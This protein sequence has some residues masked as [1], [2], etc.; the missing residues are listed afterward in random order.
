MA[1]SMLN[2]RELIRLKNVV[3]PAALGL[4]AAYEV[5]SVTDDVLRLGKPLNESLAA[6]WLFKSFRPHSEEFEKQRNLL[7]S[8]KLTGSQREYAL[9]MM[10]MEEILKE[11]KR[12]TE[13]ESNQLIDQGGM[14]LI[15]GSPIISQEEIDTARQKLMERFDRVKDYALVEG[16]GRELEN[17]ALM[18]E[19]EDMQTAKTGEYTSAVSE[20]SFRL[21]GQRKIKS[22]ENY[23]LASSPIF[24]GPQRLVNIAPRPTNIGRGPMTGKS[25][26]KLDYEIPGITPSHKALTFSDDEIL[27][28]LKYMGKVHPRFGKLEPGQ[29]TRVRMD[30]ARQQNVVGMDG[31]QYN[32]DGGRAG[33][34]G[35]GITGIRKPNA[36]APT[37]GPMH[38][39]LRSLYNNVKKS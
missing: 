1:L 6:N 15:D 32:A 24:G 21:P 17:I 13:M 8:G 26:M 35:G 19:Y 9:E 38:Q 34:M 29:G 27:N 5:G 3:G 7:Q 18:D 36:I 12:I 39:G 22:D 37:G 14:G 16:S 4:M 11:D 31:T 20:D 2:P 25:R 33:Y 30:L 10:K 23:E 28:I